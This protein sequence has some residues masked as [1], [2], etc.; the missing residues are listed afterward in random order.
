MGARVDGQTEVGI[1][2]KDPVRG[3]GVARV[4]EDR[5]GQSR[6]EVRAAG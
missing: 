2:I 5:P 4:R 1:P 6:G 3:V